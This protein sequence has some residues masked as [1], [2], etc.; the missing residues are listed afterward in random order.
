MIELSPVFTLCY[1]YAGLRAMGKRWAG[2][3]RFIGIGWYVATSIVLFTLGGRWLGQQL[4]TGGSETLFTILGV[5]L[6]LV[7]AFFGAYRMIKEFVSN[8]KDS[9]G[10]GG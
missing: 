10:S 3:L 8:T 7:V 2:A 4:D 1:N 9:D 5:L 6:G